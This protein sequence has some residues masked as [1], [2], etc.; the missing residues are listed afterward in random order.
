M[1]DPTESEEDMLASLKFIGQI[2]RSE[3]ICVK[4]K[5][6]LPDT[7]TTSFHRTF[8]NP[9]TRDDTF[10]FINK[11]IKDAFGLLKKYGECKNGFEKVLT[12][13]I[14]ADLE[15]AKSGLQNIKA[16]YNSD[17]MFSCKIDT[18]LQEI[19]ARMT[20]FNEKIDETDK[21]EK[22]DKSVHTNK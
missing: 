21:K 11:S 3:K 15:S 18:L 9:E 20:F 4:D 6:V 16:T 7:Y 10:N 19:E 8:V 13:H 12:T 14:L 5:L 1:N 17:I 2:R 22:R